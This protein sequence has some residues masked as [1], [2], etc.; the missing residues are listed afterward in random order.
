MQVRA[1]AR[2]NRAR[3]LGAAAAVFA[4]HGLRAE[5]KVIAERAGV[6]VGTLYHHFP[7]K[8]E[9]MLA[10]IR[11]ARE[12][13][14]ASTQAAEAAEHGLVGLQTLLAQAFALMERYG[15]VLEALLTGQ[16]P[17]TSQLQIQADSEEKD[18]AGWFGP[19]VQR[20]VDEGYC[21]ADL[22]VPLAAALLQ[23]SVLPWAYRRFRGGQTPEQLAALVLDT[24]LRGAAPC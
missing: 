9:L 14:I 7:S 8:D 15:W 12:E 1:D 4:E 3:I 16:L 10:I 24:F 13:E 22:N 5:V 11:Q 20:C 23:G 6:G 18:P 17:P 19:I 21:R 2:E